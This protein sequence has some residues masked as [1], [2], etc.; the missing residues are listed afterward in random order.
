MTPLLL[1]SALQSWQ[2]EEDY[3][4]KGSLHRR[5]HIKQSGSGLVPAGQR[6]R[7][8]AGVGL[9]ARCLV[10]L[11]DEIF[12]PPTARVAAPHGQISLPEPAV[13]KYRGFIAR[14]RASV[15]HPAGDTE[16]LS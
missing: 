5:R 6:T 1:H 4:F 13:W 11:R 2:S 14:R 3:W 10:A 16:L 15:R 12:F 8:S 7:Q 9:R